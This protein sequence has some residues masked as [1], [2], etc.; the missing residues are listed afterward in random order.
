[1]NLI[2][3]TPFGGWLFTSLKYPVFSASSKRCLRNEPLIC[4]KKKKRKKKRVGD[5]SE[6]LNMPKI[7][8]GC[9]TDAS[10]AG[11]LRQQGRQ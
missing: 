9:S 11:E 3:M 1:M 2:Y 10:A 5:T 4:H 6:N 8:K 7:R